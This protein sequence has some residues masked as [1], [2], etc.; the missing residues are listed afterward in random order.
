MRWAVGSDFSGM[1]S[2]PLGEQ[3]RVSQAHC[4]K[5]RG[6]TKI[7]KVQRCHT[8][9]ALKTII[10]IPLRTGMLSEKGQSLCSFEAQFHVLC[11]IDEKNWSESKI[12]LIKD[13]AYSEIVLKSSDNSSLQTLSVDWWEFFPSYSPGILV[14]F[15]YGVRPL[16][17]WVES[18]LRWT[19]THPAFSGAGLI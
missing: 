14:S 19:N 13:W 17:L 15:L 11:G 18:T 4:Q 3:G 9:R 5:R 10:V 16:G 8:Y 7:C 12:I 1:Q 2:K 6:N